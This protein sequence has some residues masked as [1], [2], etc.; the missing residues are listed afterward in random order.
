MD[1]L[2]EKKLVKQ[3]LMGNK[4]ALRRFYLHYSPKLLNFILRNVDNPKDGE[5]ILQ[6]TL[7]ASLEGLRDFS[8]RSTLYTFLCAIAKRK[9]VDFYRRK[10]IKTFVFSH[11]PEIEPLVSTLLTPDEELDEKF[12]K[13]KIKKTFKLLQPKYEKILKLKYIEGLTVKE[14]AA[15]LSISFKSAESTLFR[16]RR[17]FAEVFVSHP[18]FSSGS[19]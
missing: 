13:E 8:F 9:V 19:I 1:S 10:K 16:A 14:I 4:I 5:E 15:Q 7:L 3:I 11:L 2:E 18:E 6:D 12:L 17:E